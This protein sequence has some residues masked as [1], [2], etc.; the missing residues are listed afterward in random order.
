MEEFRKIPGFEKYSVSNLG[1]VRADK[2]G[3]ILSQ[4]NHKDGYKFINLQTPTKQTQLVHRLV[5]Y[6]FI[7]NPDGKPYIDHIDRNKT[8]NNLIFSLRLNSPLLAAELES[9]ACSG[10]NTNLLKK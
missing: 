6:A 10:V 2:T 5:G 1:N 9:R 8:N 7:P 4:F 3:R